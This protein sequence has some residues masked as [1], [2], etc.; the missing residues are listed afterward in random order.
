MRIAQ[1]ATAALTAVVEGSGQIGAVYTAPEH[2]RRGLSRAVMTELIRESRARFGLSRLV[3]FTGQESAKARSLY[4]SLG[5][6]EIGEYAL[7][8]SRT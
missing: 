2:R 4:E 8:F 1:A 7:F 3:L 5:F 6:A